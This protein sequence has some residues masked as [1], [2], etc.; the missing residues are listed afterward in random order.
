MSVG[1]NTEWLL[2]LM[3]IRVPE[4]VVPTLT[5]GLVIIWYSI[6][7]YTPSQKRKGYFQVKAEVDKLL[8]SH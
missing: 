8:T 5:I 4:L 7:M 1:F 2:P 3:N 6:W